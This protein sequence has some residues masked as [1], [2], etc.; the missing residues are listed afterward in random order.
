M[1]GWMEL[2][3]VVELARMKVCSKVG[4]MADEMVDEMVHYLVFWTVE[5][6]DH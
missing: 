3:L 1:V 4:K 6:L 2:K 5:M